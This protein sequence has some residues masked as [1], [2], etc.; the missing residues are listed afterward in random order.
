M[1]YLYKKHVEKC[2]REAMAKDVFY[3]TQQEM[4]TVNFKEWAIPR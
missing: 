4:Y 1:V 3:L 2:P